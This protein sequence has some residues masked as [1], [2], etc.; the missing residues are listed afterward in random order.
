[1]FYCTLSK[2]LIPYRKISLIKPREKGKKKQLCN[3][4]LTLILTFLDVIESKLV[5]LHA[6]IKKNAEQ[7][8]LFDFTELSSLR[9]S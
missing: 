3:F 6:Q 4:N 5:C 8:Y 7:S 1:M 9:I 2:C